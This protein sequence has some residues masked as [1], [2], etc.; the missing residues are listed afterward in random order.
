M[1]GYFRRPRT[2]P[3][4]QAKKISYNKVWYDCPFCKKEHKHNKSN[5]Y[6]PGIENKMSHCMNNNI[7][8]RI[9][10]TTPRV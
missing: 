10:N 6:E 4:V 2:L 5:G 8:I 9:S 1:D 3:T 7:N